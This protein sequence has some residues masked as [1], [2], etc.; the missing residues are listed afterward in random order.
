M[1]RASLPD[2]LNTG[3]L[4]PVR[5][6]AT[7]EE[8]V[9]LLGE[10]IKAIG[11]RPPHATQ[12]PYWIYGNLEINFAQPEDAAPYVE[13]LVINNPR[14]LRKKTRRVAPNL[15]LELH[16]L[17]ACSRPSQFI[18]AIDDIDR[19][20]V[21][22]VNLIL[23]PYVSITVDEFFEINFD[24]WAMDRVETP[25]PLRGYIRKLEIEARLA[26]IFS[27][28]RRRMSSKQVSEHMYPGRDAPFT[29]TGRDY[30]KA[31]ER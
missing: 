16:G 22:L 7:M 2:F 8:I 5:P 23:Y 21:R 31:L 9:A 17:N 14:R 6:G 30:L 20:E 18:R 12:Q 25:P 11:E 1:I 29:V 10:P 4:G 13:Y 15:M 24:H 27:L 28:D 26:D 3:C 19:I